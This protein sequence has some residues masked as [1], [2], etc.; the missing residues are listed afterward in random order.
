MNIV[1]TLLLFFVV[2]VSST[3]ANPELARA[4]KLTDSP[5]DGKTEGSPKNALLRGSLSAEGVVLE[6][7]V[8]GAGGE[9]G[10]FGTV[11]CSR[12]TSGCKPAQCRYLGYS[13]TEDSDCC[14]N[15]CQ[16]NTCCVRMGYSCTQDSDCCDSG[17]AASVSCDDDLTILPCPAGGCPK[18]CSSHSW[19]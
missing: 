7:D 15:G 19:E 10:R 5:G 8:Q 2:A 1:W 18:V 16:G 3:A 13:C 9:G 12:W 14:D 11:K 4:S 6:S 17:T